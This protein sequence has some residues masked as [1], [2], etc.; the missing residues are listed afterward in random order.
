MF[1][2]NVILHFGFF[3]TLWK[4]TLNN[5]WGLTP[6]GSQV[7]LQDLLSLKTWKIPSQGVF[8][9]VPAA[10][11]QSASTHEKPA[12]SIER[13]LKACVHWLQPKRRTARR[14]TTILLWHLSLKLVAFFVKKF[15]SGASAGCFGKLYGS[16][17]RS[18]DKVKQ[19]MAS[20]CRLWEPPW[21]WARLI[22]MLEEKVT[23]RS[24]VRVR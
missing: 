8:G 17:L 10:K 16:L 2:Q 21:P 11:N 9:P 3:G 5:F 7:L 12:S 18:C 23:W 14:T 20:V 15:T 24:T 22:K 13:L 1:L 19:G 4:W 6:Q